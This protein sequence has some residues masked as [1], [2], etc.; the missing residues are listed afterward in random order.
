MRVVLLHN[1]VNPH[2]TPVFDR[3]GAI[4]GIELRVAYFA[5]SEGDRKWIDVAGSKT[6]SDILPGRRFDL[7]FAWDYFSFHFN[8]GLRQWLREI[9]W[10]VLINSGWASWSSWQAFLECRRQGKPHVLW[11]GSTAY[12]KSWRRTLTLPFVRHMVRK[13]SAC[14][15]YGTASAEYLRLLGARCEVIPS[16]HCVDNERFL[17]H[18]ESSAPHREQLKQRIGVAGKRVILYVGRLVKRKGLEGLITAFQRLEPSFPDAVL[19]LVGD[20]AIASKLHAL[21]GSLRGKKIFFLG[22]IDM[23]DL[24]AYYGLA[25]AFV[26]PSLEEVWGLVINEAALASLPIVVTSCCGG[27]RD[28]TIDGVNGYVVPPGDNAALENALN[29]I[30]ADPANAK[31]M[32]IESRRAV[33]RF[34]PMGVAT[35]LAEA[36]CRAASLLSAEGDETQS[37]G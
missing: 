11:A 20:G 17:E 27:A 24:A 14:V 31:R 25:D 36:V 23:A 37:Q 32:G 19:L 7:S 3:L 28:L 12:E 13:S 30:L 15:S 6:R 1:I 35:A 21:A 2:M 33:D 34:N 29:R 16:F 26:L 8:P 4:N 9:E 22:N 10:D 5:A 18:L